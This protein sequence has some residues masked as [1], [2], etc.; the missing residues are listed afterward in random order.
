VIHALLLV[1]FLYYYIYL[2]IWSHLISYPEHMIFSGTIRNSMVQNLMSTVS[3]IYIYARSI[4]L[5][6]QKFKYYIG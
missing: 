2:V 4:W 1:I 3:Y 5:S 6:L